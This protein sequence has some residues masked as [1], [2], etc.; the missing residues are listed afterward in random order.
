MTSKEEI[1]KAIKKAN[2]NEI[3]LDENSMDLTEYEHKIEAFKESLKKAGG[4]ALELKKDEIPEKLAEIFGSDK[5]IIS[6]IDDIKVGT[7]KKSDIK[8]PQ[9]LKDIDIS[10]VKGDLA[11]AENGAVWCSDKDMD[12]RAVFFITKTLIIIIDRK[13]IVSNMQEAY[14]SM[15]INSSNFGVFISG[16]S[17]TA[18][19][20]Q[21]LVIGAHGAME[22]MVFIV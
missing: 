12:F 5:K 8:K 19:I 10:I 1:L 2:L 6:C 13:N 21:S 17:K 11:V 14:E 4:E 9:D 15:D 20:E 16:P 18:D 7:V 3:K 22:H